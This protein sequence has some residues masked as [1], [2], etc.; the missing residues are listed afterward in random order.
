MND[1]KPIKKPSGKEL[2]DYFTNQASAL[3]MRLGESQAEAQKKAAAFALQVSQKVG[4]GL[5]YINKKSKTDITNRNNILKD[6]F[7]NAK[8]TVTAFALRHNISSANAY[9]ILKSKNQ[10]HQP[11]HSHLED[12]IAVELSRMLVLIGIPISEAVDMS[13]DTAAVMLARYSGVSIYIPKGQELLNQKKADD[14]W[15]QYQAGH[16]IPDIALRYGLSGQAIY[17]SIRERCKQKGLA[18]PAEQAKHE[19]ESKHEELWRLYQ[20]GI[21]VDA[22]AKQ[23]GFSYQYVLSVIRKRCNDCGQRLPP[24]KMKDHPLK[25]VRRRVLQIAE[26][27]RSG[28]QQAFDRLQGLAE[29]IDSV[30]KSLIQKGDDDAD[31][32]TTK[33]M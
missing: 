17:L 14:I 7:K 19:K 32:R 11:D 16:A 28:N 3:L 6:D 5:F 20:E 8:E 30:R 4:G 2:M 29:Q 23:Y 25:Q 31:P 22:I 18:T 15:K 33:D 13:R 10:A 1:N 26:D 24:E 12:A 21:T 27:Y 9:L